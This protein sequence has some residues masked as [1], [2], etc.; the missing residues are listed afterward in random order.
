MLAVRGASVLKSSSLPR[1]LASGVGHETAG[2]VV[3]G[4]IVV[5]QERLEA[6]AVGGDAEIVAGAGG[7]A[8]DGGG[9][10]IDAG[11]TCRRGCRRARPVERKPEG[12]T[13][14]MK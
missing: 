14:L 1:T 2:N 3:V 7:G 8:E 11:R 10:L 9:E 12:G 13:T 4:Q 5:G 6:R